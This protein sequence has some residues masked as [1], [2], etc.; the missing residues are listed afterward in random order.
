VLFRSGTPDDLPALQ[1]AAQD[2]DP[3][4]AEHASWAV[5]EIQRRSPL[6]KSNIG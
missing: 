3:L 4:I 2:E 1:R 5:E 6:S